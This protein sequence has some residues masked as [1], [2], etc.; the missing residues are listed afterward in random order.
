MDVHSIIVYAQC[1]VIY[2]RRSII[3]RM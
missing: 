1:N 3:L 2:S